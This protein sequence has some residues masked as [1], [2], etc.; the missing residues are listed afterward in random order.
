MPTRRGGTAPTSSHPELEAAGVEALRLRPTLGDLNEDLVRLGT[1]ALT[2]GLRTLFAPEDVGR[3]LLIGEA[4][5]ARV[6]AA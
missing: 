3:F 2:L 1:D 4:T 6:R 5:H